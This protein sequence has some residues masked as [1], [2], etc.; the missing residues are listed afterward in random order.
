MEHVAVGSLATSV[1]YVGGAGVTVLESRYPANATMK[2]HQHLAGYVRLTLSGSLT[3]TV[4]ARATIALPGE[5]SFVPPETPHSDAFGPSGARCLTVVIE[6]G[7]LASYAEAGVTA[8]RPWCRYGGSTLWGA[9][10]LYSRLRRGAVSALDVETFVAT[11]LDEDDRPLPRHLPPTWLKRVIERI[12]SD[13]ARPPSLARLAKESAVTPNH[14]VRVF[15]THIGC[16]PGQYAQARRVTR[17]CEYLLDGNRPIS[18]IALHLGFHDQ[19]H[20][21]KVFR[22]RM[23]L[24]PGEYRS[25]VSRG[26]RYRTPSFA[27]SDG[28]QRHRASTSA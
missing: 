13:L 26:T 6:P 19:S 12:E 18:S 11:L 17:A 27:L 21:T 4:D 7:V 14:L 2:E 9:L 5:I 22:D 3:E 10:D 8:A 24:P 23:G 1:V 25:L 28:D 15:T 20:F 16:A